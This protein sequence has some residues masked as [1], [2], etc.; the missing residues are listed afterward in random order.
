HFSQLL[1]QKGAEPQK[2]DNAFENAG[3]G[4]APPD[5][6]ETQRSPYKEPGKGN[7]GTSQYD[8]AHRG[9]HSPSKTGKGTGGG[10]LHTHEQLGD[11]KDHQVVHAHG[12]NILL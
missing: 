4:D 1:P 3:Y 9:R 8:A 2:Q 5:T 10:D 7:P 11:S 12:D 6:V